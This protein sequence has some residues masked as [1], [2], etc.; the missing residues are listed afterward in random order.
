MHFLHATLSPSDRY[1]RER[2]RERGRESEK[3]GEKERERERG[4][5]RGRERKREMYNIVALFSFLQ[6]MTGAL[7]LFSYLVL[8]CWAWL[9]FDDFMH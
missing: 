9:T 8:Y 2:E 5:E 3:E 6:G 4:R 1:E 7:S